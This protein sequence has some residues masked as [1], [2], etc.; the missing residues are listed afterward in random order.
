MK[1]KNRQV[2]IDTAKNSNVVA[3]R[4]VPRP[5]RTAPLS[6]DEIIQLRQLLRTN[7]VV[8]TSCP[9]AR[10]ALEDAGLA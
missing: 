10:R 6:D 3:F 8:M 5:T 2:S 7:A 9:I 4:K 1:R